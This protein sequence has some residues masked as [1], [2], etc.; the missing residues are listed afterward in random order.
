MKNTCK[1]LL[2]FFFITQ[3]AQAQELTEFS[4]LYDTTTGLYNSVLADDGIIYFVNQLPSNKLVKINWSGDIVNELTLPFVDSL[5]YNGQL[6]RNG[7]QFYLVGTKRLFPNGQGTNNAEIWN[8]QMRSIITF[9]ED[10]VISDIA[11]FDIIPF[12]A[13]EIIFNSGTYAGTVYPTSL[14]IV[15]DKITAVWAYAIFDTQSSNPMVIGRLYQFEKIDLMTNETTVENLTDVQ[16]NLDGIYL[17]E[18]FLLY[19]DISD[20]IINGTPFNSRAVGRFNYEG[21]KIDIFSFDDNFSGGLSDGCLGTLHKDRIYSTYFGR[22]VDSEGCIENN[23]VIDVRDTLF[24]LI[25]R[26]KLPDCD[27]FPYS[28]NS[29]AFTSTEDF[30][31]SAFNGGNIRLYKFDEDLNVLCN[32][33]FFL[34]EERPVSLKVTPEDELVFETFFFDEQI[35]LYKFTCGNVND[36]NDQSADSENSFFPNPTAGTVFIKGKME[37]VSM[38]VY[39]ITGELLLKEDLVNNEIDLSNLN[40]GI[41]II[42][43]VDKKTGALV[44]KRKIIKS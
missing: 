11:S 36:T 37:N 13:G 17:E 30:Y 44:T 9:D 5:Y 26:V 19:G 6:L 38:E 42:K 1:T 31:F 22:N 43:A 40:A 27:L 7:D 8:S 29:F 25:K 16:F 15:D 4:D 2:L 39:N 32:E 34:P 12:G 18:S 10:L 23:T 14:A 35:R 33:V 21:K 24:N 28:K 41:Y 3:F 20:T